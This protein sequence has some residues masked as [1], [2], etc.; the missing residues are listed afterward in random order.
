VERSAAQVQATLEECVSAVDDAARELFDRLVQA[1]DQLRQAFEAAAAGAESAAEAA[2]Q[3]CGQGYEDV[4]ARIE[5]EGETVADA[6]AGVRDFVES[7]H[8]RLEAAQ[9]RCQD[10]YRDTTLS[11]REARQAVRDL[12]ETLSRHGFVRL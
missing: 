10:G 12:E 9:E 7:G 5:Q 1:E 3:A 6:L 2:Q 11:A 4:L 8:Q